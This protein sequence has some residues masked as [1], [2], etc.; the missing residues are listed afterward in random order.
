[1]SNTALSIFQGAGTTSS[2]FLV[3]FDFH[4]LQH[5][6]SCL[7]IKFQDSKSQRSIQMGWSGIRIMLSLASEIPGMISPGDRPV[8]F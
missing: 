6:I 5:L 8:P 7:K 1:M 4:L 2:Q 3:V